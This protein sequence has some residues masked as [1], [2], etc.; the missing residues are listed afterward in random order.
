MAAHDWCEM[1]ISAIKVIG[2]GGGGSR[3]VEDAAESLPEGAQVE[4]IDTD[5]RSLDSSELGAKTLIGRGRSDGFGAGGDPVFG[6]L[7]AEDEVAIISSMFAD[8][9]L[10]VIVCALGGGTG[11]GAAVPVIKAAR[12]AGTTTLCFATLPFS[13]EGIP[14]RKAAETMLKEICEEAD[15]V[16]VADNNRLTEV[17]ESDNLEENFAA[18]NQVIRSGFCSIIKLLIQ[19]GYINI[20][21]SDMQ[22]VLRRSGGT[23]T[24]GYGSGQ[25]QNRAAVAVRSLLDSPLLEKG[26]ILSSAKS[27]LVSVVSGPDLTL[28]EV[29]DIMSKVSANLSDSAHVSMGTVLDKQWRKKIAVTAIVSEQ[30]KGEPGESAVAA[31]VPAGDEKAAPV[32]G[33]RSP[34]KRRSKAEQRQAKLVPGAEESDRFRGAEPTRVNGEDLDIPTFIRRDIQLDK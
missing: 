15:S 6:N 12:A 28:K 13:F 27:V 4:I 17:S 20:N 8:I 14:R 10:A 7:C 22:N 11:S 19:P 18:I 34:V 23:C 5:S 30:W 3:I 29:G 24:F 25:G 32:L 31:D 1:D 33:G 16:V 26:E 21:F 2:L 9:K